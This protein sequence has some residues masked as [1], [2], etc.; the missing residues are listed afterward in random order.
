[1]EP[2]NGLK[3]RPELVQYKRRSGKRGGRRKAAEFELCIQ[4]R[5]VRT[6][7]TS[8]SASIRAITGTDSQLDEGEGHRLSKMPAKIP[9]RLPQKQEDNHGTDTHAH[10]HVHFMQ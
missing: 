2:T 6:A 7:G 1:M 4:R 5:A 8:D 9:T 3:H 10:T